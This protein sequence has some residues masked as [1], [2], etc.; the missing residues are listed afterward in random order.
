MRSGGDNGDGGGGCDIIR[1]RTAGGV[2]V[3]WWR[4]EAEKKDAVV[5]GGEG[6]VGDDVANV[7]ASGI[8]DDSTVIASRKLLRGGG[9]FRAQHSSEA[10][11]AAIAF[12]G[13]AVA[14][15][16]SGGDVGGGAGG[17]V[18]GGGK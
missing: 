8:G 6:V 15:V 2:A 12:V 13:A 10:M 9:D 7:R 11:F 17:G 1:R 4:G 5:V 16:D 3:G 14:D 18:V